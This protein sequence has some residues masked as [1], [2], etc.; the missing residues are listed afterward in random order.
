VVQDC[1]TQQSESLPDTPLPDSR[2]E[3][4]GETLRTL[5]E[6]EETPLLRYAFSLVG[7]RAVA[8][9]IVQDVFLQLHVK[10]QEV[11]SPRAWLFR[12]VRNRAFN[13]LR[14]SKRES[15]DSSHGNGKLP[16]AEAAADSAE[17]TMMRLEE[18]GALRQ[19]I[20]ELNETDRRLVELKYFEGLKYREISVQTGLSVSNVGYRLHHILKEMAVRLRPLGIDRTP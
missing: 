19:I 8:E 13:H 1:Q 20:R 18:A 9:E 16:A 15:S 4:D 12:S 10:W 2:G 7:R 5:F 14:D 11:E 3:V 17:A 6:A